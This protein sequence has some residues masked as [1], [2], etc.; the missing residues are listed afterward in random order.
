M[1]SRAFAVS[2]VL[3]LAACATH[4][5]PGPAGPGPA[6]ATVAV[7]NTSIAAARP[8]AVGD[9]IELVLPCTDTLYFGPVRF[10]AEGQH[11]T[12][13]SKVRS[14]NGAQVCGGGAFVD[15]D[16][17]EQGGAGTGCVDSA[18]EYAARLDYAYTPGAGG[19]AANPIF[20][21]LWTATGIGER[22]TTATCEQLRLHLEVT[23]AP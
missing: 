20:L 17:V 13:V 6:A 19:S 3:S 7:T 4:S 16:G 14:V 9:V 12:L 8:L 21:T 15:G 18:F 23:A 2:L 5:S 10:T 22:V 1:I 11:V